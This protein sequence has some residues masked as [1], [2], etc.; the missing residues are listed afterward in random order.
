M[1]HVVGIIKPHRPET[2][3]PGGRQY[4]NLADGI[5]GIC[6]MMLTKNVSLDNS[7]LVI[8]YDGIT[9]PAIDLKS[10]KLHGSSSY[11]LH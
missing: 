8:L 3:W 9:L 11:Q 5:P 1:S 6:E 2:A 10:S 4:F 7:K